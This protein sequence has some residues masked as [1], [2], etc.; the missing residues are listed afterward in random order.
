MSLRIRRG[1]NDQRSGIVFEQGEV[2]WTTDRQQLFVGDNITAG[3]KSVAQA[4]AG[5]GL[6][7]NNTTGKIDVVAQQLTTT[8][9]TEG[10][11]LYFTTQRAQ[12]ATAT[13]FANGTH[14]GITFQYN[15]VDN[16]I[17]ATVQF[18][19]DTVQDDAAALFT[20]SAHLGISFSYDDIDGRLIG[21]VS[22]EYIQD[23]FALLLDAGYQTGLTITYN[24]N[25][26]RIEAA[27][28]TDFIQDAVAS[29]FSNG[30]QSGIT[31][32]YDA[33]ANKIDSTVT[34]STELV[35]DLIAPMFINGN[36][37]N[38]G[39]TFT[40][41]D[42][43][44]NTITASTTIQIQ[45]DTSP[46]LGGDLDLNNYTITGTGDVTVIGTLSNN[47]V[48]II[49]D[50]ISS[51][52]NEVNFDTSNGIN[53][54]NGVHS[55]SL[56]ALST[57]AL[58]FSG[59]AFNFNSAISASSNGSI[60]TTLS[61]LKKV[62][63]K[64]SAAA[65][66]ADAI[67]GFVGT[68]IDP[69]TSNQFWSGMVVQID[70]GQVK[71]TTN[72]AGKLVF[73]TSHG[74]LN[75]SPAFLTFNSLGRLAVNQEF[76][77]STLDVNGDIHLTTQTSAISDGTGKIAIASGNPTEWDPMAFRSGK[78]YLV[79]HNENTW[80][81]IVT[82]TSDEI[83]SI[84]SFTAGS[85][86][87]VDVTITSGQYSAVTINTA[88]TGYVQ[89][90]EV[91]V[92][93]ADVGGVILDNDIK[94]FITS[95]NGSGAVTGISFSGT[96]ISGS[97]SYTNISTVNAQTSTTLNLFNRNSSDA[98][99]N[100]GPR[101][102]NAFLNA[103]AVSIGASTGTTAINNVLTLPVRNSVPTG[104]P[105]GSIAIA[106]GLTAGWD[107]KG[108]NLGV[109]YPCYYNGTSWVSLV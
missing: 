45:R 14:S 109:S 74:E 4:I 22:Q 77:V 3:G 98:A 83:L 99:T 41:N 105:I 51:T 36:V 70:P 59:S 8:D 65:A 54:T 97:S 104:V 107:P 34:I 84:P 61:S 87:K 93:G 55:S 71:T 15:D 94:I 29:L 81:S 64:V 33:G 26:N 56:S 44:D 95:V 40:Y 5:T 21:T 10:S 48:S 68:Y 72:V 2:V 106:D 37:N 7:Y 92:S 46:S 89:Y 85:G 86:F 16:E 103:T 19:V 80:Q 78:N 27:V 66:A 18:D 76:A 25:S 57:D 88:G 60:S 6:T 75:A 30:T 73:A 32:T 31:Y 96:S 11:R 82:M 12:D 62:N 53:V 1:T 24:D 58:A 100:N 101:T 91:T 47:T 9:V 102:V 35:Q 17:N 69:T 43:P 67:G 52:T 23:K 42:T 63:I 39:I 38:T 20:H 79:Y 13:L 28:S 49:T 90:Q 108:T 50:T